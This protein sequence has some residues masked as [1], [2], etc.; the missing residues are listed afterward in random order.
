MTSFILQFPTDLCL[1]FIHVWLELTDLT[2]LD[3]AA[4]SNHTER[5]IVMECFGHPHF[6]HENLKTIPAGDDDEP[7]GWPDFFEWLAIR[8]IKILT[9]G[10]IFQAFVSTYNNINNIEINTSK[11]KRID[12]MNVSLKD[13]YLAISVNQCPE[14]REIE[15]SNSEISDETMHVLIQLLCLT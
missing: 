7:E 11:V 8:N 14:L 15:F 13:D 1:H 10:D 5:Q 6:G 12:F 4:F 3:T 2:L 9:L